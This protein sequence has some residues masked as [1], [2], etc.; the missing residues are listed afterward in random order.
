MRAAWVLQWHF[1]MLFVQNSGGNFFVWRGAF[2]AA[3]DCVCFSQQHVCPDVSDKYPMCYRAHCYATS[4]AL[5]KTLSLSED[6]WSVSFQSRLGKIPWIKPYTDFHIPELLEK[7]V[8]RLA[9]ISPSFVAD[10]LETIEEIGMELREQFLEGGGEDFRLIP[11][12][13]AHDAWVTALQE[14]I[15][16]HISTAI[17]EA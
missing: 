1:L 15:T 11:C 10:C 14:M 8:K 17:L 16:E 7:G 6:Q 9:I 12:L 3:G 4:R 2:Q 5:A 13:N